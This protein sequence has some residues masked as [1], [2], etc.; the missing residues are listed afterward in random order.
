MPLNAKQRKHL[1]KL[2]HNLHP[3]VYI[4]GQGLKETVIEATEEALAAHELIKVKIRADDRQDRDQLVRSLYHTTHSDLV[5]QT[6]GVALLYR[7]HPEHP[8]IE[9]P[10]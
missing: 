9:L 5:S 1:R 4:A 8:K 3:V 2:G 7:K 10:R 6:G